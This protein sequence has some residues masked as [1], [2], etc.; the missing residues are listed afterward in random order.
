MP[1]R[2]PLTENQGSPAP[3]LHA[4]IRMRRPLSPRATALH[5]TSALLAVAVAGLSSRCALVA[6]LGPP[7]RLAPAAA[8]SAQGPADAATGPSA[9]I[10]AVGSGH[11][12]A[13]IGDPSNSLDN[14]TVRCWGSNGH[15]E[16]GSDPAVVSS[17]FTPLPVQTGPGTVLGN[18][19]TQVGALVMAP[20]Y[21]CAITNDGYLE[22]WGAVPSVGVQRL[23]SLPAYQP[24]FVGPFSS[25]LTAV[26]AA[27][28][29]ADGGVASASGGLYG[30]GTFKPS[31]SVSTGGVVTVIGPAD[32]SFS[33]LAVG[34]GHACGLS[35]VK[36]DVECWG[37][38]DRGQVGAKPP[39]RVTVP[40]AVGLGRSGTVTSCPNPDACG[41]YQRLAAGGDG[42]CA[43]LS[44]DAG[45]A[46]A[47]PAS[48]AY[49]WGANDLGQL[50]SPGPDRWTPTQ[51]AF[52]TS[53]RP[54][55][56][57]VGDSHACALMHDS[58]V[59]CW[60]DNSA[61]QLGIGP[62]GPAVAAA[63]VKVQRTDSNGPTDLH[64]VIHIAAGGKTTCATIFWSRYVWCW[65]ANESSQCGQPASPAV[66]YASPVVW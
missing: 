15:G 4:W 6:D 47:A 46:G 16:L 32:D 1:D 33:A 56:I 65:G 58:T 60:G 42:S 10:I 17:S 45:A 5:A 9:L 50:G 7:K 55:E 13:V 8:P 11:A 22:C 49:C 40:V 14:D 28:V 61:S 43:V 31:A 20:D 52:A 37:D 23:Q 34:R 63:P 57:A 59:W 64:S 44:T 39:N 29:G 38:N 48:T 30:W 25:A 27:A 2:R 35:D 41:A 3:L 62:A 36:N 51:V 18:I 66:S 12:C 54:L 53:A 21:S 19:G 26:T 24:S